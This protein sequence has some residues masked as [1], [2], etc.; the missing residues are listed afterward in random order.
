M[1]E[2]REEQPGRKVEVRAFDEP[3]LGLR[4]ILRRQGAP[5]GQRPIAAGHPRHE[6]LHLH[7]FVPPGTGEVVWSVCTGVAAALLGAVLAAVGAGEDKRIILVLDNAGRHVSGELVVPP[8][9]ELASLP[10]YTPEP[11]PAEPLRPLTDEAVANQHFTTLADLDAALRG[12][13]RTLATMPET[14]EAATH[15][16]WWPATIPANAAPN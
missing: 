4:P 11:Q 1:R 16:G 14:I 12:R 9:I 6:W 8:G 3:R 7:G 2:R 13:C 10:A 5:R 15:F